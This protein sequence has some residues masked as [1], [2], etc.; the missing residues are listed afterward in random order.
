[1]QDFYKGIHK[2]LLSNIKDNLNRWQV[3][4]AITSEVAPSEKCQLIYK[5]IVIPT[6][7]PEEISLD[8]DCRFYKAY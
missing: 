7:T 3:I 1:M 8:S 2:L 4:H 5:V 6:Q